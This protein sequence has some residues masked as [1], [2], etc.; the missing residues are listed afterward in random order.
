MRTALVPMIMALLLAVAGCGEVVT[1][2]ADPFPP[3][4]YVIDVAQVDPCTALSESQRTQLNLQYGSES[5]AQ[6][7]TSRACTWPGMDGV[8]YTFQTLAVDA[9]AAVG[10]DPTSAVL[11]IASF[12]AV[13]SAPPAQGTGLPF[14]QVVLDVADGASLRTQLQVSPQG[15]ERQPHTV[16]TTCSQIRTIAAQMLEN[17]RAQQGQ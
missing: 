1:E 15:A 17:L 5:P 9:S 13:Q 14:C 4:P 16:E 10:A 3:R 2:P 7:G 8:G 12:G 6:G 11:T